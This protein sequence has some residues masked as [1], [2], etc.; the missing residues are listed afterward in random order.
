MKADNMNCLEFRRMTLAEPDCRDPA[1]LQ[2]RHDCAACRAYAEGSAGFEQSLRDAMRVEVPSDLLSTIK[3]GQAIAV[4]QGVS[5]DDVEGRRSTV[6]GFI[7]RLGHRQRLAMAASVLVVLVAGFLGVQGLKPETQSFPDEVI[8]HIE[9]ELNHL[10]EP[11]EVDAAKLALLM[12]G[13]GGSIREPIGRVSY[14][15]RCVIRKQQGLHMVMDGKRGPVT[16]FYVPGEKPGDTRR[17]SA[18]GYQGELVEAG[19]GSLAVVG[20]QGEP[21]APIIS[22]LDQAIA[23]TP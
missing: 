7:S 6:F 8:A 17:F 14:A 9:N 3:L 4:E 20:A 18:D 15:G 2:H 16:V 21:L 10:N 12:K 5:T 1:Y 13:V 23:W 11:G 22:R 19:A